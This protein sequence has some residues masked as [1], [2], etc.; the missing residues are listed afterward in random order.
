MLAFITVGSTRFDSL[1]QIVLSEPVLSNLRLKGYTDLIIQCGKSNFDLG[2]SMRL[3]ETLNLQKDGVAIEI[4]QF[5]PS[6]QSVYEQADL[7]ISHAGMIP[8]PLNVESKPIAR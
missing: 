7:V 6:L 5:K 1:V 3:M 8:G 2:T 4:W